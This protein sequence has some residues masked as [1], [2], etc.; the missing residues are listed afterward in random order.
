MSSRSLA[1]ARSRRA[2]ENAPPVSGNRPGTSIGFQPPPSQPNVRV[3]RGQQ[4]PY[5]QQPQ[6]SQPQQ[7]QSQPQP[8]QNANGLP[9]TKLSISDAIGL[10]TIRLGRVE[11]WIIETEHENDS[12][13]SGTIDNSVFTTFA[14]RLD[15]LEKKEHTESNLE[16]VTKLSE[17]FNKMNDQLS[18]ILEE[19]TKHSLQTGGLRRKISKKW[20]KHRENVWLSHWLYRCKKK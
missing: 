17:D 9:F 8:Q 10:I 19:A 2:G 7:S 3:A 13:P 15:S 11:Q 20:N 18:R 16:V 6:Q 12:P 5:Q 14:N 1:A 4:Q